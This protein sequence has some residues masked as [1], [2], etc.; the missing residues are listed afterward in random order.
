MG[1]ADVYRMIRRRAV[2]AGIKTLIG[3]HTFRATCITTY[4]KNGGKLEIAQQMANQRIRPHD[5]S[6]RLPARLVGSA[7][8]GGVG[9]RGRHRSAGHLLASAG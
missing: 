3:C 7:D 8:L 6:L 5:R 4:L 1:Q 9:A 2:A